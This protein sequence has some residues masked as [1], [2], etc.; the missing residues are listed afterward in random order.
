[1]D[2]KYFCDLDLLATSLF[3]IL[4]ENN[5]DIRKVTFGQ[6][7]NFEKIIDQEAKNN[8]LKF[9]IVLSRDETIKFFCD[10]SDTFY[11][12]D[13]T[14]IKL[15]D[16]I[17]PYHLIYDRSYIQVDPLLILTSE[18]VRNKTLDMMGLKPT[19]EPKKDIDYYIN[20]LKEK[21]TRYSSN[22]EFEKCIELN[23]KYQEL[24]RM[25]KNINPSKKKINV[26]KRFQDMCYDYDINI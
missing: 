14:F 18:N 13:N 22:M 12:D 26:L 10:R 20:E 9:I 6:I 8:G 16:G 23:K 5:N 11:H 19:E 15:R 25:R 21:I 7:G 2:K 17:T 1:M 4:M 24:Y 3:I